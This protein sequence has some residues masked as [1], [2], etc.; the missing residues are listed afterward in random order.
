MPITRINSLEHTF[1]SAFLQVI[2]PCDTIEFADYFGSP[3]ILLMKYT[4]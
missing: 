3:I 1:K 4:T 2:Q